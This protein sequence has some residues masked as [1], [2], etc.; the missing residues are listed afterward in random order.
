MSEG[1]YRRSGSCSNA[2]KLLSA[3][4]KDAWAVQ[5]SYQEYSVYDVASVLKRFFRDLP[6]SV[7]TSELHTLLCNATKCNCS[8]DEKVILYRTI[9]ERL[10]AIN[11]VTVRK[12]LSHLYYIQLQSDKN[13]MTVL[14]LASIWGPTLMHV[15]V[16]QITHNC[17]L[18]FKYILNVL[19][20]IFRTM[21]H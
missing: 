6:E 20:Y 21:I 15:D 1:V 5:L 11:Y 18:N 8:E 12:L 17:Y 10:P 16:C 4:R 7:L 3:F 14:N 2:T 13:L 19:I 9:L